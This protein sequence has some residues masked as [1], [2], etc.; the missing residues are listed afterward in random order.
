MNKAPMKRGPFFFVLGLGP[1]QRDRKGERE[2]VGKGGSG[3]GTGRQQQRRQLTRL[4][5]LTN[6]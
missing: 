4:F 6:I 3:K 2:G 1:V 5:P